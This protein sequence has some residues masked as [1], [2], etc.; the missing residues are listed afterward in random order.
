MHYRRRRR[1][2]SPARP[3]RRAEL[4]PPARLAQLHLDAGNPDSAV[5]AITTGLQGVP[6]DEHLYRGFPLSVQGS[7]TIREVGQEFWPD[8]YPPN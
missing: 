5:W 4:Q 1:T 7:D 6:S 2:P 3:A 8:E